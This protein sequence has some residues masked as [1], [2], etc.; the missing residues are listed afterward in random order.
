[1]RSHHCL[2]SG[3][4][5]ELYND[6]DEKLVSPDE[7]EMVKAAFEPGYDSTIRLP[8]EE[9]TNFLSKTIAISK[10]AT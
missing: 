5:V 2:L 7:K 9:Q 10:I 1:M 8:L 6:V 4:D 3:N